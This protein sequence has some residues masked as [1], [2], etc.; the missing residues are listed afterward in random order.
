MKLLILTQ[1]MDLRDDVLGFFH[2]WVEAFARRAERVTVICLEK[3]ETKLPENVRVIS[4][5]KESGASKL[6]YVLAFWKAIWRERRAYDAV[7]VHM[8]QEYA[9]LGGVPWRLMG[10]R[11]AM[12]RN[13]P[14]GTLATRI[15]VMLSHK[16]FCTSPHSFTARFKKTCLMPVGI[17]TDRFAPD[18]SRRVPNLVLSLGRVAPIKRVDVI[19]EAACIARSNGAPVR[20][21]VVGNAATEA[22]KKY[23]EGIRGRIAAH[24][25][26]DTVE[27]RPAIPNAQAPAAMA[28][29]DMFV[30][31]TPD[32]SLDKTIFEAMASGAI[33][34]T[35]NSALRGAIPDALLPKAD[36]PADLARIMANVAAMGSGEK[37]ALRAALRS[38][39]VEKQ[40]LALLSE[41]LFEYFSS[42]A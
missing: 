29:A 25:R 5:G 4:L 8:N 7:F 22:D 26:E 11:V 14:H 30:N 2:G 20:L 21:R 15:A 23:L 12:W 10:K 24:G 37:D 36:D 40:S 31:M 1:K 18:A 41:R 9:L 6:G 32:G 13:H 16:V 33:A 17:D 39:V 28:E 38:Y 27:W 34:L 35:S 42:V 19:A 3:G